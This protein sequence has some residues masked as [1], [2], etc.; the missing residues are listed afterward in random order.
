MNENQ[1]LNLAVGQAEKLFGIRVAS[2]EELSCE[3]PDSLLNFFLT[4]LDG[5]IFFLKEIPEHSFRPEIDLTFANLSTVKAERFRFLLPLA[6]SKEKYSFYASDSAF[7]L[8]RKESIATFQH[9]R[10]GFLELLDILEEMH[11]KI[12]AIK[13]PGQSYRTFESWLQ[14]PL[15][16]LP[17]KFGPNLPFISKFEK[18]MEDRYPAI[19]LAKGNIH[20]DIHQ[21]NMSF[22]ASGKL[23]IL[24]LDLMQEGEYACDFTRAACMYSSEHGNRFTVADDIVKATGD[25]LSKTSPG[26]TESD[27]RFLMCRTPMGPMQSP[28]YFGNK[29]ETFELLKSLER[30]VEA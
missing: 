10:L 3:E 12:A 9:E 16:N 8:F 2:S 29:E 17:E 19:Q 5:Q 22:D 25:M 21:R 6:H 7:H 30:F 13:F 23:T 28:H 18:F 11:R 15:K 1:K 26:I 20:W 4:A 24:D 27:V 14:R